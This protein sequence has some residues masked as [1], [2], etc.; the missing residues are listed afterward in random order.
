MATKVST[1]CNKPAYPKWVEFLYSTREMLILVAMYCL[2][3]KI[4]NVEIAKAIIKYQHLDNTPIDLLTAQGKFTVEKIDISIVLPDIQFLSNKPNVANELLKFNRTITKGT[5]GTIA[6]YTSH[7][8]N[9]Q[10]KYIDPDSLGK[11]YIIKVEEIDTL[12]ESEQRIIEKLY[13]SPS[14]GQIVARAIGLGS[15]QEK[16]YAF[17][18]MLESM[19]GDIDIGGILNMYMEANNVKTHREAVI[20]IAE[21]VRK[22]ILCL[23]KT[24]DDY[25]YTDLKCQN[26]LF[27]KTLSGRIEIKVGDLGSMVATERG[28]YIAT[29]PCPPN[30]TG[31][32]SFSSS[33]SKQE[34]LS[35]QIGLLLAKLFGIKLKQLEWSQTRLLDPSEFEY[36]ILEVQKKLKHKLGKKYSCLGDLL[37]KTPRSITLPLTCRPK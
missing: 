7:K 10:G 15:L 20:E 21:S 26:V 13:N 29:F 25:V 19:D 23:F 2:E 8:V 9:K 11:E 37:D 34:C 14:C 18:S 28:V 16:G 12:K 35:Y 22:Q 17:F 24:S 6:V 36:T 4:G 32:I 3:R 31:H 1:F 27:K 30:K 5:Y 33:R